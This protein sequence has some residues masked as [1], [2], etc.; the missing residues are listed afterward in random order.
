MA[1]QKR[2]LYKS[3][4]RSGNLAGVWNDV[5]SDFSLSEAINEAGGEVRVVLARTA[6]NFGEGT[7]VDFGFQ[8]QIYCED[9][10]A[11]NGQL[12]FM[13]FI[14]SYIPT[15]GGEEK[16]EVT[17]RGYGAELQDIVITTD[18][19]TDQTQTSGSTDQEF[20]DVRVAQSFIP[21]VSGLDAVEV[22][23]KVAGTQSVTLAIHNSQGGS[24]EST[25]ISGA[26]VTQEVSNTGYEVV[27]FTFS[28]QVALS[29][30]NTYWIVLTGPAASGGTIDI[31]ADSS[32]GRLYSHQP[33]YHL[34]TAQENFDY[35]RQGTGSVSSTPGSGQVGVDRSAGFDTDFVSLYQLFAR[36]DTSIIPSGAEIT[37]A[38]LKAYQY[39]DPTITAFTVEAFNSTWT[40]PLS[41][42]EFVAASD[43]IALPQLGT[44]DLTPA[45]S[46]GYKNFTNTGSNM[47]NGINR[48]G[49]TDIMFN[50]TDARTNTLPGSGQKKYNTIDVGTNRPTLT[51]TYTSNPRIYAAYSSSDP[52]ADG[53]MSTWNGS[54]WSAVAGADL[55]FAT[56]S[57]DNATTVPYLSEDPGAILRDVIDK[58][59]ANGGTL[60]YDATTIELTGTTVSYTFNTNTALEAVKKCLEMAPAGWYFYIDQAT[61]MVHFHAKSS[62]VER[63]FILGKDIMVISPKKTI[64][65]MVN[66]ILF[67]GGDDSANPGTVLFRK[68]QNTTSIGLYGYKTLRYVDQRVTREATAEI[69]ATA[70]LEQRN[71]PEIQLELE[72]ADNNG[73]E[74][75]GYDIELVQLGEVLGIR[76]T[77]GIGSSLWDNALWDVFYWDYNIKD[78]ATALLQIVRLERNP[79]SIKIFCSTVPPDVNKRI[80]DINRNLEA[81]QTANNPN[82]PE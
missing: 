15:M 57:S 11:P 25:P 30:G 81:S 9:V 3:Y 75:G 1:A 74:R 76:G 79:Q 34:Y 78:I 28:D 22:K 71:A 53:G 59:R 64:E 40:P 39:N 48:G 55:Y 68:Y 43:T 45:L 19:N 73:S 13:G 29:I 7:D 10:D 50:S 72:I 20:T 18:L 8:I 62:A 4:D 54:S 31:M 32:A 16:V 70:I 46:T 58:Y 82:A 69:I 35:A 66:Y 65:N 27:R 42:S 60:N 26:T 61:N 67:T 77:G 56:Y 5:V 17:I 41:A 12:V 47:I 63:T 23:L 52:Y 21:D 2:Y 51:I 37:A 44:L 14:S 24:P 80:E 6:D 33:N 38:T 49:Y 36:F